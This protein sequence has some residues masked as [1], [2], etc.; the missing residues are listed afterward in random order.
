MELETETAQVVHRHNRIKE[1]KLVL[2]TLPIRPI[3][4]IVQTLRKTNQE[5]LTVLTV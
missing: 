1:V 5:E 3:S 2:L 4:L